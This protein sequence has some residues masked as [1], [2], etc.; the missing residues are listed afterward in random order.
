MER[1]YFEGGYMAATKQAERKITRTVSM[2]LEM[3]ERVERRAEEER[4][5]KFSKV[6][7]DAVEAYLDGIGAEKERAA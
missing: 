6:V 7:T 4:H 1:V 3:A 5:G 2:S